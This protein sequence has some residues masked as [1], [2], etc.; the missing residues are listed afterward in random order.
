MAISVSF[1]KITE[2]NRFITKTPAWKVQNVSCDVFGGVDRINPAILVDTS[3]VD[4][5]DTNYMYIPEFGR[6][7]F[8][9]SIVGDAGASVV[10]NGHVDVLMSFDAD[11]RKC[12]CIAGRSTS[13]YQFYLQDNRRIFY[14]YPY[15]EYRK[16]GEPI[17]E[18]NTLVL[19]TI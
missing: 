5:N 1:G 4:L 14:P 18:P 7:Y 17:G 8:I 16:I 3:R 12:K 9:T 10:V 13:N 2:D 19:I 11:I 6:Y 15:N